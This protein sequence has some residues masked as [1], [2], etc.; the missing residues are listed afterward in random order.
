M[1]VCFFIPPR[2]S[3]GLCVAIGA[4]K[5]QVFYPVI[6]VHPVYMIQMKCQGFPIPYRREA[7]LITLLFKK[8]CP[9]QFLFQ[10]LPVHVGGFLYQDFRK[11]TPFAGAPFPTVF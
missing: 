3:R 1:G 11:G 7:A 6:I 8:A 4:E 10:A 2:I 5:L 9:Q